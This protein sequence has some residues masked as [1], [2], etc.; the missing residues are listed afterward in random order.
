MGEIVIGADNGL[1]GGLCAISRSHGKIIAKIPMPTIQH[2]HIF[3]RT[4][5][6]KRKGVKKTERG[7][8]IENLIDGCSVTDW[9]L[10]TTNWKPCTVIIED[11]PDHAQQKSIMRSMGV[12]YGILMGAISARLTGKQIVVVRS[13]NPLDSW[14]RHM[15]GN[16]PKGET[17]R[18]AINKA[19]E[20]WPDEDWTTTPRSKNPHMGCVDAALIAEYGRLKQL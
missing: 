2:E 20:L 12:S 10:S 17:K 16:L 5:T 4:K 6:T 18:A 8:F 14:Q 19:R 3:E 1:T 9:I 13:G 11:C 15:L 7:L